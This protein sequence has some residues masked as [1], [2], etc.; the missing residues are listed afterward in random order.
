MLFPMIRAAKGCI[1]AQEKRA[2][3]AGVSSEPT[4]W[5][6]GFLMTLCVSQ[7]AKW[8]KAIVAAGASS[9]ASCS[10]PESSRT[11]AACSQTRIS[12]RSAAFRRSRFN[13]VAASA[14]EALPCEQ[15]LVP[16]TTGFRKLFVNDQPRQSASYVQRLALPRLR[17]LCLSE[18]PHENV[19]GARARALLREQLGHDLR[20]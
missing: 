19:Q 9:Q 13:V 14:H 10:T 7:R 1:L 12:R 8:L 18:T 16:S 15:L 20:L 17:G 6:L 4:R 2:F 3:G 5:P 11:T